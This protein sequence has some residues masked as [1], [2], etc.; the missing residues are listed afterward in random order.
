[1]EKPKI[2]A[3]YL[4]QFYP[5]EI[6]D[7]LYGKGFTEWRNVARAKPLFP[8]HYQPH[9]P[10]DLGFY[11]LRVEET[12]C[13]QAELAKKYGIDGFCYWHYWLGNG[14]EF[15]ERPAKEMLESHKP[16]F[17]FC[18]AWANHNWKANS[19]IARNAKTVIKQEYPGKT[20]YINHFYSVL[21]YLK[22]NRYIKIDKKPVFMIYQP[23]AH[24]DISEF[25]TIWR[26]L[27]KTNGLN[28]IFFI[29][30]IN[31]DI[32]NVTKEMVFLTGVDAINME[33]ITTW[34]AVHSFFLFRVIGKLCR[35]IF[36]F[37]HFVSYKR[38]MK[39]FVSNDCKEDNVFPSVI[40]NWDNT[41]RRHTNGIVLTKSTPKLFKKHLQKTFDLIKDKP[42]ERKYVF[43]KSWNEWAEGNY[44]EP[45]LKYGHGYLEAIKEAK[46][47]NNM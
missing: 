3:F 11:D 8:G 44:V 28:G 26:E 45:D 40:P 23:T 18:L 19:F 12:R 20:D 42:D 24:K 2:I 14:V 32:R 7:E 10:A 21:P 36:H 47:E 35:T 38:A 17:P 31:N 43:L 37:P 5:V 22:D 30:H 9:I 34:F 15:L 4:P 27:A 1:M 46:D 13:A 6:N 25:I 29:G 41:P 33:G 16:D 39:Y